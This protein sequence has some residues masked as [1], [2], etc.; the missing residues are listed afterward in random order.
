MFGYH[1]H[2]KAILIPLLVSI[3]SLALETGPHAHATRPFILDMKAY[4]VVT[5]S[6]SGVHGLFPLFMDSQETPLKIFIGGAYIFLV[7][8]LVSTI[9]TEVSIRR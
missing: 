1:V 7:I 6:F 5:L 2:E 9:R 3:L 8:S 4:L